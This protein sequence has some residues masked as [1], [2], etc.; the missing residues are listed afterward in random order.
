[1]FY[2]SAQRI[3]SASLLIANYEQIDAFAIVRGMS[4]KR[5]MIFDIDYT[6]LW[7]SNT[8]MDLVAMEFLARI[9]DGSAAAKAAPAVS[10][11]IPPGCHS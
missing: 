5:S 6:S 7:S 8:D 4:N 9:V 11:T 10:A 1:M 2:T 3:D